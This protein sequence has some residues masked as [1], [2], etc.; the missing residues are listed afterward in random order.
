MPSVY[1]SEETLKKLHTFMNR[2]ES[3]VFGSPKEFKNFNEA[4]N[5]L[6]CIG[7][8][9][10][11]NYLKHLAGC[12]TVSGEMKESDW[13]NKDNRNTIISKQIEEIEENDS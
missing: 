5:F 12:N 8:N 9:F 7:L 2:R 6:L 1:V 11:M 10:P 4:I 3:P 13:E